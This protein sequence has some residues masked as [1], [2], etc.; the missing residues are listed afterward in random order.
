MNE[1][2]CGCLG[3]PRSESSSVKIYDTIRYKSLTWQSRGKGSRYVCHSEEWCLECQSL[4]PSEAE[5]SDTD[6]EC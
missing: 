4:L 3:S 5:D 1:C 2:G 6:D